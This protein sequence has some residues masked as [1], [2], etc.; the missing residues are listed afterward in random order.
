[1]PVY[2]H[3]ANPTEN[4]QSDT[5]LISAI[6]NLLRRKMNAR[7]DYLVLSGTSFAQIVENIFALS[8]LVNDGRVGITVNDEGHHIVCKYPAAQLRILL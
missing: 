2:P 4:T 5:E 1:M 3:I 6:F 8:C 7:L